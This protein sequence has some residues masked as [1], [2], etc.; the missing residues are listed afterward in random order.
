M[1]RCNTAPPAATRTRLDAARGLAGDGLPDMVEVARVFRLVWPAA[2]IHVRPAPS[3]IAVDVRLEALSHHILL[4]PELA[5]EGA[6][7]RLVRE[8]FKRRV[9]EALA[10]AMQSRTVLLEGQ[11]GPAAPP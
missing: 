9:P 7:L 8:I 2:D 6:G 10:G 3:G 4:A 11:A 5:V 1:A